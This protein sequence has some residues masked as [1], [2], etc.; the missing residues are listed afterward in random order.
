MFQS[1]DAERRRDLRHLEDFYYECIYDIVRTA[2]TNPSAI[3]ALHQ[4]KVKPVR[5]HTKRVQRSVMN[6]SDADNIAGELPTLQ[7]LIRKH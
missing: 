6:I 5:L 4:Y 1:I 3:T 2:D 7:Q